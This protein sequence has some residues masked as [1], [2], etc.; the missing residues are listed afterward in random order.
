MYT[1]IDFISLICSIQNPT[2]SIIFFSSEKKLI[3]FR[4]FYSF[5]PLF[6]KI[7][8]ELLFNEK[9][10]R[11]FSFLFGIYSTFTFMFGIRIIYSSLG[12]ALARKHMLGQ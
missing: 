1:H 9:N 11:N 3:F 8:Y 6:M 7:L 2:L 4:S 10:N 12:V 5:A